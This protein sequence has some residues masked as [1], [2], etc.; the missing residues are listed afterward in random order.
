MTE[1]FTPT[2]ESPRGH[3]AV[4]PGHTARAVKL[5]VALAV[6]AAAV[7]AGDT[8]W[9]TAPGALLLVWLGGTAAASLLLG[10]DGRG[11]FFHAS[12][13]AV[14]GVVLMLVVAL[15]LHWSGVG[16]A[17]DAVVATTIALCTVLAVAVVVLRREVL[18]VGRLPIADLAAVVGAAVVLAGAG[19]VALAM[20]PDPVDRHDVLALTEPA[21][22]SGIADRQVDPGERIRVRFV[23]TTHGYAVEDLPWASVA[24][25]DQR[26]SDVGFRVEPG[27]SDHTSTQRGSA[28]IEAPEAPGVYRMVVRVRFTGPGRTTL[29]RRV[30]TTVV[31]R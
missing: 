13:G 31:V 27:S 25:G 20:Q 17:R 2:T 4:E 21:A 8:V 16:I 6:S 9:I 24:L 15:A 23:L 1:P 12:L 7:V 30:T 10:D 3:R 18:G 29:D 26:T 5:F 28:T 22:A 19:G 14:L 11:R